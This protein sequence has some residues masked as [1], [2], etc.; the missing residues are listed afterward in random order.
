M[1]VTFAH[2]CDYASV[3]R[4]GKLSAMGIF[5]RMHVTTLPAIHPVMYLAFEIE[6][7]PSEIGSNFRLGI[8]LADDDGAVIL[9]TEADGRIDA[10]ATGQPVLHI[11]QI[12]AFGGIPIPRATRYSFDIFINGD[13]K[14]SAAFDV[15]MASP[16][17][18]A[19]PGK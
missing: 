14:R 16:A 13:H 11:P 9:N 8:K 18:P 4:E 12:L 1:K 17:P 10:K 7:V 15:A 3:S 19:D 2:I 6:L 5:D